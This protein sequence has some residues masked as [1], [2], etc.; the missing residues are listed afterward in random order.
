MFSIMP[1]RKWLSPLTASHM[2]NYKVQFAEIM[3]ASLIRTILE[4]ARMLKA[5]TSDFE[6]LK[7]ALIDPIKMK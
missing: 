6:L 7:Y 2:Q 4:G 1:I 5:L 3:E